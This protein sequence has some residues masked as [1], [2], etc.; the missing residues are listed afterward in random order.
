M[1]VSVKCKMGLKSPILH[2]PTTSFQ[3]TRVLSITVISVSP[4]LQAAEL[5]SCSPC[6]ICSFDVALE[7]PKLIAESCLPVCP[8]YSTSSAN[9]TTDTLESRLPDSFSDCGC[10]L[11]GGCGNGR[12]GG[13]PDGVTILDESDDD[14]G[15]SGTS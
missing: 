9:L 3:E 14:A 1:A 4:S 6:L 13:G 10:L 2:R 12:E 8:S 7:T 11:L 5:Q 15:G